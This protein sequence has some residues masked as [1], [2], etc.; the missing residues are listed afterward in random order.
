MSFDCD[1]FRQAQ[2]LVML[3]CHAFL[4]VRYVVT[5]RHLSAWQAK[6]LVFQCHNIAKDSWQGAVLCN[7]GVALL[8]AGIVCGDAPC[9]AM[10]GILCCTT[11]G[12]D[13][14]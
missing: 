6:F 14:C 4:Q 5:V 11:F 9:R 3:A 7:A 1:L 12:W 2:Y 10:R 13:G 8:V